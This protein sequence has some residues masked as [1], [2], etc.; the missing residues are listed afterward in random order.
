MGDLIGRS[1]YEG[2][3]QLFVPERLT[4]ARQLSGLTKSDLACAIGRT[5]SAVSQYESGRIRPDAAA[6]RLLVLTLG[7]SPPFFAAPLRASP[8]APDACHFRSLRSASQRTRRKVLATATIVTEV[9]AFTAKYVDFPQ[10]SLTALS[11][12]PQTEEDIE[13]LATNVRETLGL[14]HGPVSSVVRVAE[15]LG[16]F[17]CTMS[18]GTKTV[19]AFSYVTDGRPYA[20]LLADKASPSRTR[21]DVAHELGHLLMHGEPRAGDREHEHQAHRFASAFLLPRDQFAIECPRRLNFQRFFEL[22]QRWRVSLAA[23]F[24]RAFDLKLLS[25]ASYRNGFQWLTR[26]G[27]RQRER[28]EPPLEM[29]E[30]LP[31]ATE[32]VLKD[33]PGTSFGLGLTEDQALSL[34][35]AMR[36]GRGWEAIGA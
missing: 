5:T 6:V 28:F 13:H 20:F 10:N 7:K 36:T 16:V 32:L 29:P 22:K 26:T 21:F 15:N 8:V 35:D 34:P 4:L 11:L 25:S 1:D 17:T 30:S 2:C 31:G 14:G 3:A 12:T 33:I 18:E 19:D 23:L 9:A 24:R 27:Q